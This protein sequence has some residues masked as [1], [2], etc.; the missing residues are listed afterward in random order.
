MRPAAMRM[1]GTAVTWT[2][3]PFDGPDEF[4]DYEPDDD[5]MARCSNCDSRRHR[6]CTDEPLTTTQPKETP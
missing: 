6:Y 2:D 3:D 4:D 5:Y 1:R